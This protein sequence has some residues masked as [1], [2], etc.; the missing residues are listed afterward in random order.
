MGEEDVRLTEG[1]GERSA[2]L[3]VG[4]VKGAVAVGEP[5]GEVRGKGTA[6]V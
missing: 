4:Y 6:P 5:R 2:G 3:S 1:R